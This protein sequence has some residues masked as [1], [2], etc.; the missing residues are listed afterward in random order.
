MLPSSLLIL[1]Q[2][3]RGLHSPI[4]VSPS[5]ES[6]KVLLKIREMFDFGY[7]SYMKFAYPEDELDPIHCRGRGPDLTDRNNINVNDALGDYQ[8]TLVDSL[9]SLAVGVL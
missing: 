4:S 5:I 1:L 6:E 7:S 9:D 2:L 8:L 3:V